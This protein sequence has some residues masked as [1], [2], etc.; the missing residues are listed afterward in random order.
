MI[1]TNLAIIFNCLLW[2]S[3][4]WTKNHFGKIYSMSDNLFGFSMVRLTEIWL[5]NTYIN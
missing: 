5:K 3:L 4:S 1:I 2:Y